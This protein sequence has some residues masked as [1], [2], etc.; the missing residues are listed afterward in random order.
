MISLGKVSHYIDDKDLHYV[1]IPDPW[2]EHLVDL[3]GDNFHDKEI[4]YIHVQGYFKVSLKFDFF[5]ID[6]NTFLKKFL[7]SAISR[8]SK[9]LK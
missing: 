5:L 4:Q 9:Y 6:L 3:Q 2:R 7:C 1:Y 8:Y